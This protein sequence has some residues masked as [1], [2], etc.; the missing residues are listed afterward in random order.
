MNT[1]DYFM[2]DCMIVII[3]FTRTDG[4]LWTDLY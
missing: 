2:K 3:F 1:M 4:L